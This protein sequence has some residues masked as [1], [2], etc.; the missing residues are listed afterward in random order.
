MCS[1]PEALQ[2]L[3]EKMFFLVNPLSKSR[4]INEATILPPVGLVYIATYLRSQGFDCQVHDANIR[5][6]ESSRLA[7]IALRRN[8]R[9]IGIYLNSF[10]LTW[11]REF[12]RK[13]RER[14]GRMVIGVGGPL[15]SVDPAKSLE[16]VGADFAISGEGEISLER[17]CRNIA[18]QR[19]YFSEVPGIVYVDDG[20]IHYGPSS[21][22]IKDLDILP[23]PEYSLIGKLDNNYKVRVVKPP[24]APLVTS[25]GCPYNCT[26]CSKAVFGDRVTFRSPENVV[27]EICRLKYDS[28]VN[29]IDILDDNFT[30][31][32]DRAERILDLFINKRLN[33]AINLQSGV[34]IEN[35]DEALLGKMKQA[36]VIKMGFGIESA[37]ETVLR[38]C[39]KRLDLHKVKTIVKAA[40][41]SGIVVAGFFI[42][43]LPGETRESVKKTIDFAKTLDLDAASFAMAIPFPGTE[44]YEIVKE[45]GRFLVNPEEN[46]DYGF[47]TSKAF[48]EL[49][50]MDEE[51]ARYRFDLAYKS[52]YTPGKIMR[53]LFKMKSLSELR[54][55]W[56]AGTSFLR[57]K[58]GVLLSEVRMKKKRSG[59]N[60]P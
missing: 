8:P 47:F 58:A 15:P 60:H 31:K 26:Y 24:S 38:M 9:V 49:E 42:M 21:Q 43:G 35:I 4:G 53:D 34:H 55:Y 5:A 48:F 20:Q 14:D 33:M 32:K 30:L 12:I 27:E 57:S 41:K 28:G 51:E 22:R 10:M 19:P 3:S 46:Y 45:K 11:T 50:G 16:R 17:L 40:K 1:S 54:W 23:F 56:R 13:V 52:F 6:S 2:N 29:Q 59:A 7:D 36:N 44:L 39:R 18:S 25:R 37:E